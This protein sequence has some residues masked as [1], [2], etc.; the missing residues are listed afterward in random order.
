MSAHLDHVGVGR[1]S[2]ATPSITA[3]WTM[4][5]ESHPMLEIARHYEGERARS[6]SDR[7][8]FWR[9]PRKRRAN[10]GRAISRCSPRWTAKQSW[11][12]SIWICSCRCSTLKCDRGAGAGGIHAGRYG[13]RGGEGVRRGGASGQGAGPEPLYPQRPVQLHP[14]GV[15]ALAF[16]F[17]YEF[18]TPEDK[19]F[20][21][22]VRDRYHKPTDDLNQP[23]DKAAAAKFD[24]MIA[25]LCS[26]WPMRRVRS[27]RPIVLQALRAVVAQQRLPERCEN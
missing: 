9:W 19:I 24:R 26:G 14:E 20:H 22:W 23:V 12:I 18:G 1:R 27:G 8:S 15:P 5:R 13:S 21:D 4:L 3:R 17:G 7:S 2:T 11:P 16:K 25:G 6:R 10:W